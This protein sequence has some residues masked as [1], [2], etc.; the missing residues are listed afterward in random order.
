VAG[1]AFPNLRYHASGMAKS[2][3][4]AVGDHFMVGLRPTA[5]L[6]PLDRALLADLRPVGVILFKSNFLHDQPCGVWADT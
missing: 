2:D 1:H 5:T 6:H 3:I 4:S